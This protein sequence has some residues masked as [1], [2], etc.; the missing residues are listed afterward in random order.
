MKSGSKLIE[1][2]RI[3]L[4]GI[5]LAFI[6]LGNYQSA[7]E[8]LLETEKNNLERT[9]NEKDIYQKAKDKSEFQSEYYNHLLDEYSERQW[10]L[11]VLYPHNFRASFLT[12]IISFVEFELKKICDHHHIVNNTVFSIGDLKGNS[13][14]E[15][16]KRYLSK[17]CNVNFSNLEPEWKFIDDCRIVRNKIIHHQGI[18]QNIDR[19]FQRLNEFVKGQIGIRYREDMSAT[20]SKN[21]TGFTLI[22]DS[23]D[24]CENLLSKTEVFFKR[25][26]NEELKYSS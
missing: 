9:F 18:F 6:E 17:V 3:H 1:Y 23:K 4:F 8:K 20:K 2:S 14:I 24:F 11:T 21:L 10:E 12:Q 5:E 7:I 15:K 26:L 16:C 13:E 22:I 19:D 25:L